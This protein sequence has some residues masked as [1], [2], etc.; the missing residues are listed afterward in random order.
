M[1]GRDAARALAY[2]NQALPVANQIGDKYTETAALY[3]IASAERSLGRL[4]EARTQI[5]ASLAVVEKVRGNAVGQGLRA[6]YLA[7]K[8]DSY[9]FYVDLLMQMNEANPGE[10]LDGLALQASERAR[11]RSLLDTLN[12]AGADIKQGADPA[13]LERRRRV[14]RRRGRGRRRRLLRRR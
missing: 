9:K 2:Y 12:Q 10:G 8:E 6:A 13:L 3:G 1:T 4:R 11:A 14:S 5:E 7:T